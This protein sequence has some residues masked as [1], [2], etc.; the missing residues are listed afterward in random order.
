MRVWPWHYVAVTIL[1]LTFLF[2]P[3]FL[4]R[5]AERSPYKGVFAVQ[6]ALLGQKE[7]WYAAVFSG[8]G[9]SLGTSGKTVT[10]TTAVTVWT[11]RQVPNYE[12][13]ANKIAGIIFDTYPGA[14]VTDRVAVNIIYGYDLGIASGRIGQ[15]YEYSPAEWQ[16]RMHPR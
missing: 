15:H 14:L 7:V 4:M 5:F 12:T 2:V 13:F 1:I 11:D 6:S 9:M 3:V 10:T 16:Q 8:K